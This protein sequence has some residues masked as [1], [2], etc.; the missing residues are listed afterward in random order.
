MMRISDIAHW[1]VNPV[2]LS[3]VWPLWPGVIPNRLAALADGSVR[4]NA[5]FIVRPCGHDGKRDTLGT[6]T[7]STIACRTQSECSDASHGSF[8]KPRPG[9][10]YLLSE[11]GFF[12][13]IH[14]SING[15]THV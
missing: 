6:H 2:Q 3:S 15:E 10:T 4:D 12:L 13:V 1:M 8:F 14:K 7:G 9:D 5:V 11:H